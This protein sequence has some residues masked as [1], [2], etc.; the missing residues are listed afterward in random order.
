MHDRQQWGWSESHGTHLRVCAR[1]SVFHSWLENS[2]Q[3]RYLWP[4]WQQQLGSSTEQQRHM[5]RRGIK[6]AAA[7]FSISQTSLP[8]VYPPYDLLLASTAGVQHMQCLATHTDRWNL[9]VMCVSCV[10][11]RPL[12]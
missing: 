2:R 8:S 9:C 12:V 5:Q 4:G 1:V 3:G 11:C 7:S 6:G 10:V